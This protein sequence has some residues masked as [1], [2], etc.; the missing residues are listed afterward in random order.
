MKKT[1]LIHGAFL[2]V[3]LL[4]LLAGLARTVLRPKDINY[5]EN[6]GAYKIDRPTVSGILEGT[7]QT[8]LE[9][10]LSD[11]VLL[12]QTVKSNYNYLNSSYQIG[13][14]R[15]LLEAYP[16]RY[17]SVLGSLCFGG[18]YLVTTP[19]RME[20]QPELVAPMIERFNALADR[21]GDL[22]FYCFYIERDADVDFVTG[23]RTGLSDYIAE[24]LHIPEDHFDAFRVPDFET[25]RANFYRTDHHWNYR[26]SY[27]AYKQ[28]LQMLKPGET[29]LEP[30][31]EVLV[32][33]SYSG[34]RSLTAGATRVFIEEFH[35]YR[36]DLPAISVTQNGTPVADYGG[37]DAYFR[38]TATESVTYGRFYGGDH[39]EAIFDRGDHGAGS[40]LIFG[41]SYD[42][43]IM[44]L[45]ASHYDRIY[46]IDLRNYESDIGKPFRFSEYAAEHEIDAVLFL[47]SNAF[48]RSENFLVED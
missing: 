42:N 16:D 2:F 9:N 3:I 13:M 25:Y 19:M 48:F 26:G 22:D 29:P 6:R 40:I 17:V 28:I 32:S 37:Q 12:A 7:F 18:E 23:V 21:Y 11:Q 14:I 10:A 34:S 47:G 35:A 38:G 31:E 33:R 8:S 41:E 4:F 24:N 30:L 46:A 20:D 43:A 5:Y 1:N 45:L 15:K 27:A 44:K 39:G 36:F